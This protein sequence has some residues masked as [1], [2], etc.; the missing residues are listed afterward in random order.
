MV[1]P[2]PRGVSPKKHKLSVVFDCGKEKSPAHEKGK[3]NYKHLLSVE[4]IQIAEKAIVQFCQST[5]YED[6]L[7]S[8]RKGMPVKKNIHKLAPVFFD[9]LIKVGGKLVK[10]A[11]PQEAK[12]PAIPPRNH[13]VTTLIIRHFHETIEHSGQ[14]HTLSHLRQ[15]YWIP[16]AYSAVRAVI[17]KCVNC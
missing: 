12:Q 2:T 9:E 7:E 16:K 13:H 15:R 14:N 1:Y 11:M 4:D 5:D 8:L 17:T 3:I 6:E 10:S